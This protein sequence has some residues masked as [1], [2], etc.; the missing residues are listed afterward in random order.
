MRNKKIIGFTKWQTKLTDILSDQFAGVKNKYGIVRVLGDSKMQEA[1]RIATECGWD[2]KTFDSV[3]TDIDS[4]NDLDTAPIKN[5]V[6]F[7]RGMCRMGKVV[8]KQHVVFVMETASKSNTDTLLQGLL[9][10]MCGY[11][12]DNE[13]FIYINDVILSK[14]T[15]LS[16]VC[17]QT[18][19]LEKYVELMDNDDEE[20]SS[21]RK[22]PV[23]VT[24]ANEEVMTMVD[25]SLIPTKAAHIKPGSE[26]KHVYDMLPYVTKYREDL[27]DVDASETVKENVRRINLHSECVEARK[28]GALHTTEAMRQ[29]ADPETVIDLRIISGEKIQTSYRRVPET[30]RDILTTGKNIGAVR[31]MASCG[32]AQRDATQMNAWLFRTNRYEHI[33]IHKGTLI[34]QAASSVPASGVY[35]PTTTGKEAFTSKREDESETIG[36]GVFAI[37]LGADTAESV[38]KMKD[39]LDKIVEISQDL[40][41][42][43]KDC[44]ITSLRSSDGWQSIMVNNEVKTAISKGGTIFKHIFEKYGV[45][46]KH[47]GKRGRP[48]AACRDS[49]L[50]LLCEISW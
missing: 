21:S 20:F 17:G 40:R 15:G 36:N 16:S 25:V 30:F 3:V 10:R 48:T 42:D 43:S 9:G 41:T 33:G 22:V 50:N 5:T 7:I 49:G 27:V 34:L 31:S 1:I 38:E 11:A 47:K 44:R 24:T 29:L 6:I 39:D 45:T 4:M 26:N 23:F 32:L 18:T 37:T 35:A 8:P 28:N 46:L 19:E 13:I 14:N 2:C 12:V